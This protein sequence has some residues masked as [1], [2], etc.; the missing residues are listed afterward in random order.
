[1]LNCLTRSWV[2]RLRRLEQVEDV[3]CARCRP[4][5]E[6]LLIRIGEGPAAADRDEARV[7]DLREDHGRHS[8]HPHS[9]NTF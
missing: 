1:M 9:P 6:E 7:S 5:G 4:K 8:Y 2:L 3:L